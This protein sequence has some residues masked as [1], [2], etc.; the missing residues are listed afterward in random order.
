MAGNYKGKNKYVRKYRKNSKKASNMTTKQL[1]SM[2]KKVALKTSETKFQNIS[3]PKWELYHN[4]NQSSTV[5]ISTNLMTQGDD[6]DR[7]IGNEIYLTGIKFRLLLGQKADRP[8]VTFKI[9]VVEWDTNQGGTETNEDHF[10]HRVTQNVMLDAIQS[11]RFKIL[12]AITYK[13]RLGSLEVGET[14]KEKTYPLSFWVPMRRKISF[15]SDSGKYS[16]MGMKENLK[17]V[18]ACYDAYGTLTSDNI[19]YVQGCASVYYKDP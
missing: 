16:S 14:S 15:A 9:Y 13:G 17:V 2:M 8:N 6:D 7:R 3:L 1:A 19:G 10:Y 11:H 12:K 18:V 5:N 4:T